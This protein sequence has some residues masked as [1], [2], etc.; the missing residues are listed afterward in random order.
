[1]YPI[2]V[3]LLS[4]QIGFA[5]ANDEQEHAALTERGYLPALVAAPAAA[6]QASEEH[7]S[8]VQPLAD[9]VGAAPRKPGRP[10]KGA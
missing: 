10:R 7:P 1:M 5:V 8:P 3:A 9:L 6:P 4:P 2:N